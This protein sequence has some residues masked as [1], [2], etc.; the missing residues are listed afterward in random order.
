MLNEHLCLINST[1]L[2]GDAF[3]E[4]STPHSFDQTRK[5]FAMINI[6]DDIRRTMLLLV[7]HRY[8]AN[9]SNI[10]KQKLKENV[11]CA[12]DHLCMRAMFHYTPIR[13]PAAG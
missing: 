1:S 12:D 7:C 9:Y 3:K 4:E 10:T 6:L 5:I 13:T 2:C 8:L 11:A